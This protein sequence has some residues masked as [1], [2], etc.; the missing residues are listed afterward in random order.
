MKKIILFYCLLL[1]ATTAQAQRVSVGTAKSAARNFF[2]KHTGQAVTLERISFAG[3]QN[4][5]IFNRSGADGF[6]IVAGDKNV[7]PVLAYSF[8]DTIDPENNPEAFSAWLQSYDMSCEKPAANSKNQ[9]L[10]NNLLTYSAS[11]PTLLGEGEY[12][13]PMVPCVWDQ[14]SP[15]HMYCPDSAGVHAMA[16]C[17]PI[18]QAQIMRKWNFPKRAMGYESYFEPPYG[19]LSTS[20]HTYDWANMFDTLR[21]TTTEEQ[22]QNVAHLI[23]DIGISGQSDYGPG[24]TEGSFVL[25]THFQYNPDS[26]RYEIKENY[27]SAQWNAMVLEELRKG[28]PLLYVGITLNNG[29][30][31]FVVDGYK[32]NEDNGS[33]MFHF[34]MG[35]GGKGNG[36]YNLDS[37]NMGS[38]PVQAAYL[39]LEP[40]S[41]I[42]ISTP[43]L[44]LPSNACDTTFVLRSDYRSSDAV[45]I[46]VDHDWL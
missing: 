39:G 35:W 5:Y 11:A 41:S 37:V 13:A 46:S 18:A 36:Y 4:I 16:G 43:I 30:H 6:V 23:S 9:T 33:D 25:W 45:N 26:V 15:Y 34:N 19:I 20:F 2:L 8:D 29:G 28:R 32:Y 42:A 40:D 27:T 21:T 10:W 22:K 17:V 12:I 31:V 24:E 3:I 1:V 14:A 38:F 7:R 44:L